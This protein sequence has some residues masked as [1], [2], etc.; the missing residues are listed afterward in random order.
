MHTEISPYEI[1]GKVLDKITFSNCSYSAL[2]TFKDNTFL[3]VGEDSVLDCMITRPFY[4]A[5]FFDSDLIQSGLYTR[6]ELHE[7]R[8]KEREGK[9]QI[10]K[11]MR[12]AEYLRLAAEFENEVQS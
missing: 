5:D 7:K 11:D 9:E 12:R 3:V 8:K 6:T 1:E 4:E 10:L 2:L